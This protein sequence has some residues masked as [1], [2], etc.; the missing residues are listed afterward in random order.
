MATDISPNTIGTSRS[1]RTCRWTSPSRAPTCPRS[2]PQLLLSNRPIN[3]KKNNLTVEVRS[4]WASAPCAPGDGHHRGLVRGMQ[5]TNNGS[6]ITIPV[7]A[8][9]WAA[10]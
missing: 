10:S 1:H 3:D 8:R 9:C 2:A 4:I 5:V 7:G 6:P